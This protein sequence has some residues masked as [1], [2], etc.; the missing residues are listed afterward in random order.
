MT[1]GTNIFL[2]VEIS[3]VWEI[4]VVAVPEMQLT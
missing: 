1:L 2:D 3:M 4:I